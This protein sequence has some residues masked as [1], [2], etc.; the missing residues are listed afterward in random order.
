MDITQSKWFRRKITDYWDYPVGAIVANAEE[1]SR[2]DANERAEAIKEIRTSIVTHAAVLSDQQLAG[3]AFAMTDD[4]YKTIAN[5]AKWNECLGEYLTASAG[6]LCGLFAERG[7]V[8]QY[9][10]DNTFALTEQGMSGPRDYFQYWFT[11]AGFVYICAQAV[12]V[13]VMEADQRPASE[14]LASLPQY[15]AEARDVANRIVQECQRGRRSFIFLDTDSTK[16]SFSVAA[17]T[18][19]GT[20]VLGIFRVEAPVTGS[21]CSVHF[22]GKDNGTEN[23][24]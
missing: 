11:A 5:L 10:I 22:P 14:Y 18:M 13:K 1:L 15:I 4:L 19:G 8:I 20:E 17:S 2:L 24:G 7:Y 3:A 6:T 12:A 23:Q 21:K 16:D 9:T